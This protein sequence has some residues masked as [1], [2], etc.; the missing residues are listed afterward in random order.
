LDYGSDD[1]TF[2]WEFEMGPTITKVHY[3]N[4][5]FEDPDPSPEGIYPF[6]Q[7][8]FV[9][10]I[11]GDDGNYNIMLTVID[12]DGGVSTYTTSVTI[13]NVAPVIDPIPPQTLDEGSIFSLFYS[14][15]DVG[16]D[17]LLFS[18]QFEHGPHF[19]STYF[20]DG[21]SS[22]PT[23]SPWGTFPF[24]VE[25]EIAHCYGDNGNYSITLTVTDDDG[26]AATCTT[27]IKVDNV[28]P[29]IE[30]IEAIAV[31]NFTLRVAGEKWHDVSMNIL[32]D[33]Y[34][35]GYAEVMRFPG[36]PDEQSVTL[37]DI[38]CDLTKQI[39]VR[40]YYTPMD[41]PVNGQVKGA[42][43]IW[44]I[45]NTEAGDEVIFHHTCNVQH[46]GS[47]EWTIDINSEF[48]GYQFSL[49]ASAMDPGSDDLRFQWS[50]GSINT[51]YNDGTNPDHYPS[52]NGM[53]PFYATDSPLYIYS[54][55]ETLTLSVIDDD[56][57]TVISI[58]ELI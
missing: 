49:N 51:Y 42:T 47:W 4:G 45:M 35:I 18:W 30:N 25:D 20:N 23:R 34:E 27:Y 29:T 58:I 8:D 11:Y 13:N 21:A 56:G 19:S 40:I 7:E 28:V 48:M 14:A 53:F 22:D 54:G 36:N 32:A 9:E 39:E 50:F 37:G 55:P 31:A 15:L 3:N 57:G 52:P 5:V 46:P 24:Q 1:L 12:D 38:K 10:Y 41:D 2:I 6:I 26:G 33:G 17:D 43:P 16:S 44:V